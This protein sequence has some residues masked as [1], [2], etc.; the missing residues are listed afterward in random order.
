MSEAKI[1]KAPAGQTLA[2]GK[3]E[4]PV[5]DQLEVDDL[6]IP[7]VDIPVMSDERWNELARSP[8]NQARLR[9]AANG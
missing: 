5:T 1:T 3:N 9:E 4:Y 8:E 2:V 6:Q 7:I